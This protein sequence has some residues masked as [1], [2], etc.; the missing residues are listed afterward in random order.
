MVVYT[1]LTAVVD[2][3][4]G[5]LAN[6]H[7]LETRQDRHDGSH[8]GSQSDFLASAYHQLCS[9]LRTASAILHDSIRQ[10]LKQDVNAGSCSSKTERN[11]MESVHR[12][13]DLAEHIACADSGALQSQLVFFRTCKRI[14]AVM[15]DLVGLQLQSRRRSEPSRGIPKLSNSSGE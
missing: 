6:P 2:A 3:I 4:D 15:E 14:N 12:R 9:L 7:R 11:L 10:V 5:F 13:I 1:Q 8:D